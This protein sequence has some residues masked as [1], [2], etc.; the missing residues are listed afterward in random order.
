MFINKLA[1]KYISNISL[2]PFR[3]HTHQHNYNY[4]QE[5]TS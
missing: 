1:Q 5:H 3:L 4:L 2:M